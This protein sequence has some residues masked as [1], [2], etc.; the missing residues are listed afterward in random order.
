MKIFQVFNET[1]RAYVLASE[2]ISTEFDAQAS[3]SGKLCSVTFKKSVVAS[4]PTI[5]TLEVS[6]FTY[7]I[8]M[9]GRHSQTTIV[10]PL[11]VFMNL[12]ES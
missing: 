5:V 12:T 9:G 10:K 11:P 2:W 4:S 8:T 7:Y 6:E 1:G 3:G